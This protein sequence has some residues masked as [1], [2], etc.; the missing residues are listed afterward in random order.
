MSELLEPNY[1]YNYNLTFKTI[2]NNFYDI[3][4]IIKY[5]YDNYIQLIM[6][7]S[8]FFIIY[9]VDR[10]NQYNNIIFGITQIPGIPAITQPQQIPNISQNNIKLNKKRKK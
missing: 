7:I 3:N 2:D 8:V 5:I 9:V 6:L 1:N 4:S 10:I